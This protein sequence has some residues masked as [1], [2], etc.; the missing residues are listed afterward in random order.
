MWLLL[1]VVVVVV[2]VVVV[3]V[4]LLVVG[5][6]LLVVGVSVVA[7]VLVVVVVVVVVLGH[8]LMCVYVHSTP[9]SNQTRLIKN[10]C[11]RPGGV[12]LCMPQLDLSQHPSCLIQAVEPQPADANASSL[13]QH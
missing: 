9:A 7:V 4:V 1:V 12:G 6:W 13:H 3:E 5:C 10:A 8:C 2:A 11:K